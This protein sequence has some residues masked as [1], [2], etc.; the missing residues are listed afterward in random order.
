V[1]ATAPEPAI[2]CAVSSQVDRVYLRPA[3]EH[4]E[5]HILVGRGFPKEYEHVDA[6]DFDESVDGSFERDVRERVALRLP[7]LGSMRTVGGRVGLYDVTPDWHP[8]LGPA[9]EPENLVLATGGS[10]HCFKLAP[11][12][13]EL[14]AAQIL[15]RA[16][17]YADAASFSLDRFAAGRTFVSTYGG[18]RA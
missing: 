15:D 2:P 11:A 4:G 9:G 6:D 8:L 7:R 1:F 16:V 5:A 12:I 18:N 3:P 14:V 13:G 10:G 17:P